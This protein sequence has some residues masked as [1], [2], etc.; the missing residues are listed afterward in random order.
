MSFKQSFSTANNPI[1]FS[2]NYHPGSNSWSNSQVNAHQLVGA[3]ANAERGV[4]SFVAGFSGMGRNGEGPLFTSTP[5]DQF[6]GES[7]LAYGVA[8]G[9]GWEPIVGTAGAIASEMYFSKKYG[10]WMGKNF[11]IYQQSWGGNGAT[12]GKNKF[13]KNTSNAIKWG[14]RAL[15][16]WS[17]YTINEQRRN[18][19][20]SNMQWGLEQSSNAYSTLGGIYGAAWG[21]GWELGRTITNEEWY[22]VAKFNFWYNRWESQVGPPSQS[23]ETLWYY[24]YQN[25][26][27]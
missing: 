12:G 25:Y 15:G 14:G 20:V 18:G 11:K 6:V 1:T 2:A 24:F 27:P 19:E 13:A 17:A 10:T 26:R 8:T 7:P 4:H 21:V 3:M 16:A 9:L 22:Q 23:N 5:F